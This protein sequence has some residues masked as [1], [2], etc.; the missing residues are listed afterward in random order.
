VLVE[1]RVVGHYQNFSYLVGDPATRRALIV[2]PSFDA[3]IALRVAEE[4]GYTVE[5]VLNTHEHYDHCQD[6]AVAK[7]RSGGKVYAHRLADVPEKDHD[8]EDGQVLKVGELKVK[9]LHTP[10]HSPGSVLYVVGKHCFTGDTLFV[11]NIGRIDLPHSSPQAMYHSLFDVVAKLDPELAV[12][13]GHDYGPTRTSTIATELRTNP[14]LQK[15]LFERWVA[16]P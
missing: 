8:L 3:T 7:R 5:A 4:H 14:Y 16:L 15:D 2:D 10:G 11:G 6:N 1:Q 9:V 13:P 12:Q